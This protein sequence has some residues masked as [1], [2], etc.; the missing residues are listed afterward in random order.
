MP[1]FAGMGYPLTPGYE[2]TGE[3]V[4][5]G[6]G[7]GYRVG[8]HVFVPGASCYEGAHGL[9]GAA[10]QT[11]VTKATRVTMPDRY[12]GHAAP[13]AMY[14]DAGLTAVDIAATAMQVAGIK[15]KRVGETVR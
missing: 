11:L 13:D 8:E 4:E 6:A 3:V 12:T 2:A 1:P 15:V 14:A 5:V 9:F 7:S 10:A